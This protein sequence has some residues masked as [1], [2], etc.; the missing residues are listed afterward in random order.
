ML[1]LLVLGLSLSYATADVNFPEEEDLFVDF[2]AFVEDGSDFVTVVTDLGSITGFVEDGVTKFLGIPYAQPPVGELRFAY[3]QPVEAYG[4]LN[5]TEFG[6]KCNQIQAFGEHA[7]EAGGSEDCLFLNIFLPNGTLDATEKK[8]VM[9]WIHG[10]GFALGSSNEYDH[11]TLLEEDVILVTINYRLGAFG[12]LSFGNDLLSGNMG[13]RDQVAALKWVHQHIHMFNGDAAR[14]TVFGESAGGISVHALQLSPL[15][16]GLIAGGIAQSGTMLMVK[17]FDPETSKDWRTAIE[18]ASEQ[19]CNSTNL[20]AEMLTCLQ[21]LDES[22]LLL[23]TQKAWIYKPEETHV[24]WADPWIR[25]DSFAA[26]P[27]LPLNPLEAMKTGQINDFPL[28][29]GSMYND[30]ALTFAYLEDLEYWDIII[31]DLLMLRESS[32][33]SETTSTEGM[34]GNIFHQYYVDGNRDPYV[35]QDGWSRMFTDAQFRIPDQK[36]AELTSK[37]VEVYDYIFSYSNSNFTLAEVYGEVNRSFSPVHADD[38][39]YLWG[40]RVQEMGLNKTETDQRMTD[41]LVKYWAN[42]AKYG[43]PSPPSELEDDLPVWRKYSVDQEYMELK[44]EPEM[45]PTYDPEAQLLWQKLVWNNRESTV[46]ESRL[47]E[48]LED[49]SSIVNDL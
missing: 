9:F 33:R 8:A 1:L 32:N 48:R 12:F 40:S 11:P 46:K 6:S 42:F 2:E 34:L 22:T 14:I 23:G 30:G 29:T 27:A 35:N 28:M 24:H 17:E 38:E 20:D 19:G 47:R 39:L 44:P 16:E 21:G 26:D 5:A 15:A 10:G 4:E 41:V 37:H 45:R 49:L 18:L 43:T 31:A 25:V 36:T 13:L 3:P 7:G